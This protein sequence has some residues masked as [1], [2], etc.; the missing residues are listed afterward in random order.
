MLE[1]S[2]PLFNMCCVALTLSSIEISWYQ[3]AFGFSFSAVLLGGK[4]VLDMPVVNL[5]ATWNILPT[6]SLEFSKDLTLKLTYFVG[7]CRCHM[8]IT[9]VH[10]P[11]QSSSQAIL[12]LHG[13]ITNSGLNNLLR[14]RGLQSVKRF[15]NEGR[16]TNI[17]LTAIP[18]PS[19]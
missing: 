4:C 9:D 3:A 12:N 2:F 14:S 1:Y 16:T 6:R 8:V 11:W 7:H 18:R 15:Y 13:V 19:Q 10:K 17:H 5:S